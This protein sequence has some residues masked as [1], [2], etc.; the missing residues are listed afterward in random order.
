MVGT[1]NFYD[2]EGERQHT[3][4]LAATPQYGKATFLDRLEAEV[5]H[6]KAK[7]PRAHYAGIAD[8]ARGNWEFLRRAHRH[9]GRGLL[10]CGGISGQGGGSALPGAAHDASDMDGRQLSHPETRD[11]GRGHDPEAVEIAV[12]GA[13]VGE[14]QRGCATSD[15]LLHR[16]DPEPGACRLRG[17]PSWGRRSR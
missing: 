12:E 1:I 2:R 13:T 9:S 8:G 6:V 15:H 3:V 17:P 14:R 4:C 7:Y 5:S 10:A 11:R 16:G